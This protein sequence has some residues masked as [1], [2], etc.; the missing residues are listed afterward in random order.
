MLLMLSLMLLLLLLLLMLLLLLLLLY[1]IVTGFL[2]QKASQTPIRREC[3]T[4]KSRYRFYFTPTRPSLR[5]PTLC[6]CGGIVPLCI[7]C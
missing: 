2:K 3:A 1:F 6:L 4:G 5:P 7:N